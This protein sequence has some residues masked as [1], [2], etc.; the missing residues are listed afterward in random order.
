ME[1]GK[2]KRKKEEE[3]RKK[4]KKNRKSLVKTNLLEIVLNK[5]LRSHAKNYSSQPD[6]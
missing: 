3:C 5:L 1:E 2:K 4:K 6:S